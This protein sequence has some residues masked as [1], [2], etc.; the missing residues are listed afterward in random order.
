MEN[1]YAHLSF[2]STV[3][4]R[5]MTSGCHAPMLSRM[6]AALTSAS[7]ASVHATK[8]PS[9]FGEP[10]GGAGMAA[11]CHAPHPHSSLVSLRSFEANRFEAN[12]RLVGLNMPHSRARWEEKGMSDSDGAYAEPQ[13]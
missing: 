11:V 12:S 6:K 9:F 7:L 13:Q 10:P 2:M 5:E 8:S 3:T 1:I 4:A